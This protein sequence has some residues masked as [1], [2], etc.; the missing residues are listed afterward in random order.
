MADQRLVQV[1][2]HVLAELVDRLTIAG[3]D[4]PTRRYIHA[5]EIAH[6]FAG[7]DCVE[8]LVVSWG[9]TFQGQPGAEGG[10]SPMRCAVPTTASYTIALLRCVP[11]MDSMGNPPSAAQLQDSGEEILTDGMALAVAIIDAQLDG[12]LVPIPC[13]LVG[14]GDVSPVGPQGGVGGSVAQ[15]VVGLV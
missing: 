9:G 11:T 12:D 13:S 4:V 14:L 3:I 1:A 2:N 5:G 15:I 8:A 6:D 7:Q 10:A